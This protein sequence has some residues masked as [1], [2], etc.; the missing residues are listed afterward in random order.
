MSKKILLAE[1][2]T[3]MQRLVLMTFAGEDVELEVTSSVDEA[4]ELYGESAPDLVIA[5]LSMEGK[6]GYDLCKAVKASGGQPVL[7]L[8]GSAAPYDAGKAK[9]AGA[10]GEITKPFETGTMIEKVDALLNL[11]PSAQE[12]ATTV[13]PTPVTEDDAAAI[14]LGKVE[15]L[16]APLGSDTVPSQSAIADVPAVST[17]EPEPALESIPPVESPVVE[18]PVVE[19]GGAR[20]DVV[21]VIEAEPPPATG[22]TPLPSF[23]VQDLPS[24]PP[25]LDLPS[26]PGLGLGQAAIYHALSQISKEVIEKVAWEVVPQ[27]A[28]T[29]LREN[30]DK[31]AKDRANHSK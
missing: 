17:P 2:S 13:A 25:G 15:A 12:E 9:A 30:L 20:K 4:L 27:L 10:D 22:G 6:N 3:T 21:I 28:E 23:D 16:E 19:S 26:L 1:D 31:L 5:D 24:P 14:P 11:E 18:A 7:L 29:L 8:H